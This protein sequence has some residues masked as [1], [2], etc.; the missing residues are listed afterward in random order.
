MNW[1]R[2]EAYDL[3]AGESAF[4][5]VELEDGRTLYATGYF[6]ARGMF[7]MWHPVMK[8]NMR[9]GGLPKGVASVYFINPKEVL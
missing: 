9:K 8:W 1:K 6:S 5:K 2:I 7:L 3:L 4:F